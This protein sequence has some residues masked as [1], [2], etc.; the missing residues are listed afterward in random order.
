MAAVIIIGAIGAL[1]GGGAA[2]YTSYKGVEAQKEEGAKTRGFN[3]DL[4][5]R[6]QKQ[7][8]Q[9]FQQ[10]LEQQKEELKFVKDKEKFERQQKF[11]WNMSNTL[12]ANRQQQQNL[13]LIGK[14]RQVQ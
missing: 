12:M 7:E 10:T 11:M 4:F 5:K 13:A 6:Q 3:L 2:I 14:K 9:Q 8:T 1:A